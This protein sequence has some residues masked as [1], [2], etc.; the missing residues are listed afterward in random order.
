M[1]K[2][3][4]LL[5]VLL[6]F[7]G[8]SKSDEAEPAEVTTDSSIDYRYEEGETGLISN[9]L[10]TDE[11]QA[12]DGIQ[13]LIKQ[14]S[15]TM[16]TKQY[17]ET[18]DNLR[19]IIADNEAYIQYSNEYTNSYDQSRTLNMVIRV[20]RENSE[21]CRN[22]IS[23]LATVTNRSENVNDVTDTYSDIE[24]RLKT[25]YIEEET[26]LEI[27]DKA[28]TVDEVLKVQNYL[29]DTRYQIERYESQ[30]RNYDLLTTYDTISVNIYEVEKITPVEEQTIIEEI[31]STF[32]DSVRGI[33][34]MLRNLVVFVIGDILY[35][36]LFALAIY[37]LILLNKRVNI[38]RKGKKEDKKVREGKNE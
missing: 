37:L 28:T 22:D 11:Q 36:G 35:I 26:Y 23:V 16:E 10:A 13:K 34:N 21:D 14:Y 3:L 2:F 18:L 33:G 9:D 27:L 31:I 4:C 29:S 38:V 7:T 15:L 30:K 32:M 5:A 1:K 25:L 17:D 12:D 8:C 24:A 19:K 20:P 6:L